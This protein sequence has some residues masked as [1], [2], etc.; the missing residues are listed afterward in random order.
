MNIELTTEEIKKLISSTLD[1]VKIIE[2]LK[3]KE[4]LTEIEEQKLSLNIEHVKIM[5]SHEWFTNELTKAQKTE[6]SKI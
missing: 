5:I 1:S 6:L 2:T 3:A 4:T